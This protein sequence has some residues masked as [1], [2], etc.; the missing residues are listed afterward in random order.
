MKLSRYF[1]LFVALCLCLTGCSGQKYP[2]GMPK[3][4]PCEITIQQEGQ[5]L[6]DAMV[7]LIPTQGDNK[8]SAN[9]RTDDAGKAVIYTWG[10]YE[11]AAEG[12]YK[13]VVGKTHTDSAPQAASSDEETRRPQ[14]DKTYNLVEEVYSE[15]STTPLEIE[16]KKGTKEFTLDAGKAIKK[17]IPMR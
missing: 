1:T 5:P 3:L 6:A 9:G 7:S 17:L 8:W 10:K 13:V 14:Q 16:L 11:G 4:V 12:S 2:D 15:A